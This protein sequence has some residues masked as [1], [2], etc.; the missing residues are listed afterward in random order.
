M[1]RLLST[2]LA[3]P[4]HL[5]R[6][7]LRAAGCALMMTLAGAIAS[8]AQTTQSTS[9]P[10]IL[11]DF[12]HDGL[13]D[14]LV[15]SDNGP[16]ATLAFGTTPYG[17]F[18]NPKGVTFPAACIG[19]FPNLST[20]QLLVGD[21]N[22]D[23]F[24]D[25]FF[26]CGT[27]ATGVMLGNGDGTF[28]APVLIPGLS[29]VTGISLGDFD[30]DG[31][32]DLAFIAAVPNSQTYGL[33]FYP[34]NGDGTFG[35]P[36]AS[37]FGSATNF[38][39]NE[40]I[41]GAL[42]LDINGDGYL[43][44]LINGQ[45]SDGTKTL[46]VFGNNKNGT[47]GTVAQT[48]TVPSTTTVL[49]T[50]AAVRT[51]TITPANV[52]GSGLPDLIFSNSGTTPG[53]L[54]LKNTSTSTTYSFAAATTLTF[55]GFQGAQVGNFAGT[56]FS[57]LAI[58]NGTSST[59]FA[60]DGTGNFTA[61]YATLSATSASA[62]S[63][64]ADANADGYADIYTATSGTGGALQL[65]VNLVNGTATATSQP[66]FLGI[67]TKAV[68]AT[69]PGNIDITGS[70]ATGSQVVNG[71]PSV[72]AVTSSKNP[73]LLGDSVTFVAS[74][75]PAIPTQILPNPTG[76]ITLQ[77]NGANLAS[78]TLDPTGRF[79]YTT[80]A[81]TQGTHAITA[82][83]AGD[84]YFAATTSQ[85][86]SQVVNHA[87]AATPIITW[88]TPAA[89]TYGT[90][91]SATQLNAAAADATG[92]TI[93]G[94][95]TYTPAAG[96]V[97]PAGLQNLSVLFT[98][99]DTQ[100]FL[101]ATKTVQ[102]NILKASP[103]VT[104]AVTS[105]GSA[106]TSLATGSVVTLTATASTSGPSQ[107]RFCD[108]SAPSCT[109]IHLLGTAQLVA[110]KAA[111]SFVPG[112]GSHT[113]KA[114]LVA[115]TNFVSVA[116]AQ[117]NLSVTGK[118]PSTTVIKQSGPAGNYTLTATT[119]GIAGGLVPTGS[120]S[121]LD[122]TNGNALLAG[123][124][125]GAATSALN[126]T[127]ASTPATGNNPVSLYSADLN[128]DGKADLLS[129]DAFGNSIT[130]LLGNGDGTFRAVARP[131]AAGYPDSVAI[132]DFNSDGKLDL[133]VTSYYNGTV[134]VMSGN[135]DGTFGSGTTYTVGA[136]A[137]QAITGD[138]NGDGIVDLAIS[139]DSS[140]QI[141]LGNG[142]GTFTTGANVATTGSPN[143]QLATADLNGDGALDLVTTN[144][145]AG[146]L[147]V[148]LGKGD[149]T[150]TAAAS[151]RTGVNPDNV[152]IGD[153]NGDGKPDIIA[154]GAYATSLTVLLGN[155][156]G[157]F[158]AA[159]S[160][161]IGNPGGAI[162]IGDFN[163]D[164][165]A[166][167]AVINNTSTTL[168]ILLGNGDGTFTSNQTLTPTAGSNFVTA[169]DLDGDGIPDLAA[170]SYN[171]SVISI[172]LTKL[173]Q[174]TVATATSVNP[175]GPGTHQVIASYPG[176][177]NFNASQSSPI[178][179]SGSQIIPTLTWTPAVPSIVYGTPLGTQQLNATA[180]G[181]NGVSVPGTFTYTP[182]AGAILPVGQQALAV[183]FTPSDPTYIPASGTA[184]IVVTIATPTLTWVTPANIAYGIPLSS[185]QLNATATGATGAALPGV[186]TY[187]PA[188]G[189]ILTPGTQS[190]NVRFVPTDTVNYTVATGSVKLTVTGV[191][192]ASITPNM[193]ILGDGDKT[194]SLT[195]SG[196][197]ASSVVQLGSTAVATTYVNP[198]TLTAVIPAAN[199][200]KIG[201]FQLTVLD[202]SISL[203]S[204]ALT[205]TVTASTPAVT[206]SGPTTTAPGS[207]PSLSFAINNP[208]P[209]ALT[210]IFNLTFTP[211]VTPA[212]DD[213]A[214]QFANGQRT[215]TFVIPANSTAVPPILL[216]SGTVAGTITVPV[217]LMAG[218][219]N[220]T[221]ANLQPVVIN[222]P[223]AIPTVST[224]TLI[225][226]GSQLS[227]VIHGFSNTREVT[228]ATFHIVG[229]G[230]AQINTPDIT[231]PVGTLFTGWF[232]ST[233]SAQYGSTFT[234]TQV[235]N[236]S[237]TAA[238]V[239]SVQVTLTNSIGVS[240]VQTAQ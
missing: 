13:P 85:A 150:F 163:H 225:R 148:L 1:M 186:F 31:K 203:T 177:T 121:F 167:L 145:S 119:T 133:A 134:T 92:A 26:T 174:T 60:N 236:V 219:T 9:L 93:P 22:G 111:V 52:Y 41:N 129:T 66:F 200:A 7:H 152:V 116:S 64:V 214:I 194:I 101:T 87:A 12:N 232:G 172:L 126:F 61:N 164:G 5:L 44:L 182:A 109:D 15:P 124:T 71:F 79:A 170:S 181:V 112:V 65:A 132:A 24:P 99:T 39:P 55:T 32:L 36:T 195:G 138:F 143:Y 199:F 139:K 211:S 114:I 204:S 189:T 221:P 42:A 50:G 84:T 78:G 58:F 63:A 77:D 10:V 117:S 207:Q 21:F 83:Y 187:T 69:W 212:V 115:T 102:L 113:Y 178:A 88:A 130:V 45:L 35:S 238:N 157:T 97:L 72:A 217:I 176:D 51:F 218:G 205:F 146:T 158:R 141:L 197:V 202:P 91:L 25:L 19:L 215:Y 230:G 89:I 226:N 43:D 30:H 171:N 62:L 47:F 165:I 106:V 120:V 191:T 110:G 127:L 103:T 100:S 239:G 213:Q 209:V 188:A 80:T 208:Y 234:Y 159:A 75:A 151:P 37:V 76:S 240:T 46:S 179:L 6:R 166:D 227:V 155:G 8:S 107:I 193:A 168:T 54:V 17:T 144:E 40:T 223:P 184:S 81:L 56:A 2:R 228:Q 104:L 11:A 140:I 70:T 73:S 183:T 153:F 220:V 135:G 82:V 161:S 94:V 90:P 34:G 154:G 96:T 160:P 57:D 59:V 3:T 95:F 175:L 173:T 105:G 18:S 229:V 180:T 28:A 29:T 222:I 14:A 231:A 122:T 235:F 49:G 224:A 136:D 237:D 169:V 74:V 123:G 16:S 147:S 23:G 98:P 86:L 20:G 68:S 27:S 210:A 33:F 137:R 53:V 108:A 192:L 125:L 48:A 131:Q 118:F 216:Q 38:D 190:L 162:S 149:G 142:D 233:V 196:F 185:A 201:T 4:L 156:D 206:L 198:T 67:G 128:G